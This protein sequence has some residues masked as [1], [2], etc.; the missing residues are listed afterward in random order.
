M[1]EQSNS[2]FAGI[3]DQNQQPEPQA[4]PA[5][6]VQQNPDPN[7]G[8]TIATTSTDASI[9]D[10]LTQPIPS[11]EAPANPLASGQPQAQQIDP[12]V[13]GGGAPVVTDP[14]PPTTQPQQNFDPA[15]VQQP[16]Q[17]VQPGPG[18]DPSTIGQPIQQGGPTGAPETPAAPVNVTGPANPAQ[19]PG[20]IPAAQPGT[21]PQQPAAQP[22]V[23]QQNIAGPAQ[24]AQQPAA[25]MNVDPAAAFA[26]PM[27]PG[28]NLICKIS[29]GKFDAFIKILSV[30]NEKNVIIINNSQICQS[31]NNGSAIVTA[32][33]ASLIDS[34]NNAITLHILNPKKYLKYFK[35]IKGE[36][37]IHFIDD[38]NN[39]RYIVTNG[40][41]SI[42]LPKQIEALEQD[43]VSPDLTTAE[44][45][46]QTIEID[47]EV[48]A[49]ITTMASDS[50]SID[51]LLHSNQLKGVYIPETAVY[52]FKDYIK[53]QI[54]DTNAELKLRSYSFLQVPGDTYKISIGKIGGTLWSLTFVNTG[55]V[56]ISVLENLQP[57]SDDNLII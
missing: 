3:V 55:L 13:M 50:P 28:Q 22:N 56:T 8:Q 24:V 23:A 54:D 43:A 16:G 48:R 32:N 7:L 19:Q 5:P 41:M 49:I 51:L 44:P 38:M 31:I 20:T 12:N 26:P 52:S 18:V 33:I 42:Y 21:I 17:V 15:A 1:T 11:E 46:G 40:D 2:S 29:P 30:L 57:V 47:K 34:Q 36:A 6:P 25:Q 53:D 45:I 39:E 35:N 14:G 10:T 27:Q 4:N 9:I 37:D